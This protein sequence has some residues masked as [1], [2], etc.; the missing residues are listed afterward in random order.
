[1]IEQ[2]Y[3]EDD[4]EEHPGTQDFFRRFPQATVK[5]PAITTKRYSTQVDKILDSKRKSLL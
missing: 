1:M 3:Y 2:I 5:Y 4:L